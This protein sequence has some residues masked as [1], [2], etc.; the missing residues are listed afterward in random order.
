MQLLERL[1]RGLGATRSV[2]FEHFRASAWHLSPE[3][4]EEVLLAADVGVEAAEAVAGEFERA[5]RK[6]EIGA[7]EEADW[8]RR[9]VARQL[10]ASTSSVRRGTPHVVLVVGVNGTGKTTTAAKLGAVVK[11]G[12]GMPLLVA[13]DTFRAAA[14]EQL[15]SWGRRLAIEVV[16]QRPGADPGA[17]V[18]DALQ[19]AVARGISDVLIDTAGRLHTKHNLMAELDK[20]R[21]VCSRAVPGSPHEVLLV[22]DASTGINGLAQAREFRTHGG[23]TGV[24]LTKLDG[25]AKGGVVLAVARE[26]QLPVRWI[27]VGETPEDL[28]P[29]DPDTFTTA[30]LEGLR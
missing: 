21:R 19:A 6:G 9:L 17:V 23:A 4:L 27:G 14:I 25:T 3:A 13:A 24:V 30:L 1:R 2:L 5:R 26:L 20:V 29:F 15:Q 28:L 16:A 11:A 12:G 10:S 7:G 18:F 8:L 22:L